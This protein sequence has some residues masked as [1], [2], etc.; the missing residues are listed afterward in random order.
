MWEHVAAETVQSDV[1]GLVV[2]TSAAAQSIDPVDDGR[3]K[4]TFLFER[5]LLQGTLK[6]V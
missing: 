6:I 2:K 5:D 1:I 3:T 4:F